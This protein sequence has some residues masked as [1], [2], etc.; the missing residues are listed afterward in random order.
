[1]LPNKNLHI[2]VPRAKNTGIKIDEKMSDILIENIIFDLSEPISFIVSLS[3]SFD[4]SLIDGTIV[5]AS[6]L[7]SVEGIIMIGNVIPMII[8]NSD[9]ASELE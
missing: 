1:M 3:I 6:E 7:M 5:T 8:P 9:K 2:G 4:C